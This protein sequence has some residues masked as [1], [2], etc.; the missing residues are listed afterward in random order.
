MSFWQKNRRRY[1]RRPCSVTEKESRPVLGYREDNFRGVGARR[2]EDRVSIILAAL[3]RPLEGP[4]QD[5]STRRPLG[6]ADAPVALRSSADGG[7]SAASRC[8]AFA[9]LGIGRAGERCE[10]D[11]RAR[12]DAAAVRRLA[13][14]GSAPGDVQRCLCAK[15]FARVVGTNSQ[16][17][18]RR[19]LPLALV[20]GGAQR[21]GMCSSPQKVLPLG[22]VSGVKY[23]SG[24]Q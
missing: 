1:L 24:E 11:A 3:P 12:S 14:C 17:P 13:M 16:R 2:D 23:I 5:P 22:G 10:S 6:R 19:L 7:E 21:H 4:S 15:R 20:L 18:Q 8:K 9:R